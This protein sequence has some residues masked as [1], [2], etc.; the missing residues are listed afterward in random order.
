MSKVTLDQLG[1]WTRKVRG[2]VPQQEIVKPGEF[3]EVRYGTLDQNQ[4]YTNIQA[5]KEQLFDMEGLQPK[6]D[7]Y[8]NLTGDDKYA[9]RDTEPDLDA[10]LDWYGAQMRA[11]PDLSQLIN[12]DYQANLGSYVN[13]RDGANDVTRYAVA[14]LDRMI[15]QIGGRQGHNFG[16]GSPF[17]P[18][19]PAGAAPQQG[20][21][22]KLLSSRAQGELKKRWANPR[23]FLSKDVYGE[24]FALYRKYRQGAQSFEQ[25]LLLFQQMVGGR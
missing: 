3:P 20:L 1:E 15:R 10:Y 14:N 18:N 17:I 5:T 9:F 23:F 25:W 16:G 21:S 11:N 2:Y 4:R 6:L 22:M 8:G 12:P 13:E 7:T 19:A 24:L